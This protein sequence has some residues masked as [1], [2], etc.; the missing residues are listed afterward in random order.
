MGLD[1][2][3]RSPLHHQRKCAAC[4]LSDAHARGGGGG[5]AAA[6]ARFEERQRE[7]ED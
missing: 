4:T 7:Q 2:R 5:G 6:N 1:M 3:A